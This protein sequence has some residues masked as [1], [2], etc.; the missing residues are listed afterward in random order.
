M[1]WQMV[2]FKEWFLHFGHA[3]LSLTQVLWIYFLPR[4]CLKCAPISW[5]HLPFHTKY[6]KGNSVASVIMKEKGFR[7]TTDPH[8]LSSVLQHVSDDEISIQMIKK[9]RRRAPYKWYEILFY[10]LCPMELSFRWISTQWNE[11]SMRTR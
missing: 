10:L 9:E 3:K 4:T 6:I 11:N 1:K 2:K 8:N 7:I 5:T